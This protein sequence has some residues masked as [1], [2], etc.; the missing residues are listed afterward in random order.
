MISQELGLVNRLARDWLLQASG[1]RPE[2]IDRRLDTCVTHGIIAFVSPQWGAVRETMTSPQVQIDEIKGQKI[3][4]FP[5]RGSMGRQ[6]PPFST[7]PPGLLAL[8]WT[9]LKCLAPV[10]QS[11]LRGGWRPLPEQEC[12][13]RDK[14][15]LQLAEVSIHEKNQER[16]QSKQGHLRV[17]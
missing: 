5:R 14:A 2:V 12:V 17:E 3:A 4:P 9:D 10:P 6:S 8:P 1:Q 15:L 11:V 13:I 16:I 7:L